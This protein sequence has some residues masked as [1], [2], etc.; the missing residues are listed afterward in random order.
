MSQHLGTKIARASATVPRACCRAGYSQAKLGEEAR[1][2]AE[3][4]DD[5]NQVSAMRSTRPARARERG[6]LDEEDR[7][8]DGRER[9]RAPA[10]SMSLASASRLP[11]AVRRPVRDD[12]RPRRRRAQTAGCG[13]RLGGR[14]AP[15]SSQHAERREQADD[16]DEQE[17]IPRREALVEEQHAER[18]SADRGRC[19]SIRR[20][21]QHAALRQEQGLVSS[22]PKRRSRLA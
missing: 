16:D 11:D 6:H 22:P 1:Q 7:E 4:A 9:Q 5:P 8:H 20:V 19:P 14:A 21:S 3:V 15:S 12:Q 13:R 17:R 2:Q 10:E 18:S